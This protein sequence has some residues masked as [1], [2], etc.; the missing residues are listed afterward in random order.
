[1]Y[2][3]TKEGDELAI[4]YSPEESL[5]LGDTLIIDGVIAQVIDIQFADLP[6]VLEH[7]LRKSLISKTETKEHIQPEVKSVIDSLSDQK[8]AIAKIRGRMIEVTDE[9]GKKKRIF[10]R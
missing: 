10:K 1:M 3:L 8:L 5:R 6:G 7:I 9:K 2:L 4:V